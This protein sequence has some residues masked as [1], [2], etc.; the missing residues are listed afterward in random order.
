[1]YIVAQRVRGRNDAVGVNATRYEHVPGEVDWT[2]P[3]VLDFVTTQAPGRRVAQ[4]FALTPGG[5]AVLSYADVVAAEPVSAEHMNDIVEMLVLDAAR[6]EHGRL[7]GKGWWAAYFATGTPA[8]RQQELGALRDAL[9][10][11][12][13]RH[14]QVKEP[15]RIMVTRDDERWIFEL[16][17]E[18]QGRVPPE[19]NGQP[20]P[21][22]VTIPFD[23]ARDFR[24][25]HG[26]LYPHVIQWLTNMSR[27]EI[28]DGG[29]VEFVHNGQRV[30]NLP[31]SPP[32]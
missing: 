31:S 30:W 9:V 14:E 15:L 29:G 8:V 3:D 19:I 18:S 11:M 1:M 28:A 13:A 25:I 21:G 16:A 5:N 6:N 32:P 17:P 22:R 7:H 20:R 2:R 27:D 26:E 10:R 12:A 4:E 24:A 23:V